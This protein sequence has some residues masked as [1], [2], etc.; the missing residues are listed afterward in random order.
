MSH[1]VKSLL[2]LLAK[3][4]YVCLRE[5]TAPHQF[6]HPPLNLHHAGHPLMQFVFSSF[7]VKI[8]Q[9][10]ASLVVDWTFY[11]WK[12]Q[13]SVKMILSYTSFYEWVS[14]PLA[15]ELLETKLKQDS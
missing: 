2:C 1:L 14:S 8:A 3:R 5:Q 7:F 6:L 12:P 4:N 13:L 9:L 15:S 10:K 11:I